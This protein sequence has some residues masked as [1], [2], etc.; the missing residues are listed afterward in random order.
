MIEI[1]DTIDVET[2]LK[3][4][5]VPTIDV[6]SPS[7]FAK[8]HISGALNIPLFN[9]D[10]RAQV[11][12][13]YKN[14]GRNQAIAL[15]LQLV[16]EKGESLIESLSQFEQGEQVF[17]HCWR[18]GMR[19]EAFAWL[20]LRT[21]LRSRRLI[22]GYKAFRSTAHASFAEHKQ[23]VILSGYTGVGKTALLEDLRSAG[24]QVIDLEA[25]ACHRGSAF[26]GIGQ[27][28]QPTVEQFENELFDEWS[29]IDPNR[30]VWIEDE[31]QSIGRINLPTPLWSQMK[32]APGIFAES[33]RESRVELL[34]R[35]YGDLPAGALGDAIGRVKK[36]LGGL[37]YQNAMEALERNEIAKFADI[38]LSYYDD[39][40][41]TAAEKRPRAKL[42]TYSLKRAGVADSLT[43][44]KRLG[45]ELLT[46]CC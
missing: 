7:E 9:D 5:S 11:G 18:G 39:A 37:R 33:D 8:G 29:D 2:Y 46:P 20:T 32:D 17:V 10:E 3:L 35:E 30:P 25:L 36:R 24:E 4:R 13:A 12:I 14:R 22:G 28:D 23:I 19:S 44:L 41:R 31:S 15:G 34:V 42:V 1:S 40:Y 43:D 38:A 16:G 45:Q 27:P 21:G 6:R 26:G